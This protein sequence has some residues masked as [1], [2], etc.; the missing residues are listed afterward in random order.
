MAVMVV[1]FLRRVPVRLTRYWHVDMVEQTRLTAHVRNVLAKTGHRLCC[2][3]LPTMSCLANMLATFPTKLALVLSLGLS[4]SLALSLKTVQVERRPCWFG[5]TPL[6][7]EK[8][9][10]L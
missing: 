3:N 8:M 10:I 6:T 1:L 9:P 5:R 4:L 7:D 2:Q